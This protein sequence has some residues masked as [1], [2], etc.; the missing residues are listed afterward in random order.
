MSK[1]N[2][3]PKPGHLPLSI[4]ILLL[5]TLS[6]V[7]PTTHPSHR[8]YHLS[9]PTTQALQLRFYNF[10]HQT[11]KFTIA[12]TQ[13]SILDQNR[14]DY[15]KYEISDP[16]DPKIE[17]KI[18]ETQESINGPFIGSAISIFVYKDS[19]GS[20]KM[21]MRYDIISNPLGNIQIYMDDALW[22]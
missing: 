2:P 7:S 22:R 6:P 15:F 14:S 17:F 19:F 11:V 20:A 21:Q 9:L 16:N 3:P 1:L 5:S 4:A 13:V 10:Y 8:P 18:N 12:G